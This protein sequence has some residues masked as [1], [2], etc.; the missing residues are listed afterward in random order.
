MKLHNGNLIFNGRN[1]LNVKRKVALS[2][3]S[4]LS[5]RAYYQSKIGSLYYFKITISGTKLLSHI[6]P[7]ICK[8]R[9]HLY[10]KNKN[11]AKPDDLIWEALMFAGYWGEC[12]F[13]ELL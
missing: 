11:W 7:Q 1:D 4:K 9:S 10:I 12:F 2:V 5:F 13:F 6:F 8:F 3:N